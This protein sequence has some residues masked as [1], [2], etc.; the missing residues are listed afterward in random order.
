MGDGLD[1]KKLDNQGK[2]RKLRVAVGRHDN[3]ECFDRH[4]QLVAK[5][6]KLIQS[7]CK[8]GGSV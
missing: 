3:S 4:T 6:K 7:I 1:R 5:R 8:R 2:L